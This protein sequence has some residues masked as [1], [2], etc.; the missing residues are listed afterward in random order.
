MAVQTVLWISIIASALACPLVLLAHLRLR[1]RHAELTRR[2][3]AT[4]GE[5][6][7]RLYAEDSLV[8]AYRK[9]VDALKA[10]I[11]QGLI[12]TEY[13]PIADLSSGEVRGVEALTRFADGRSPDVWFQEAAELGIGPQL[14]IAAMNKAL[15]NLS[16]LPSGFVSLNASPATLW[17]NGFREL[18]ERREVPA[19]RI[20]VE[21]TEHE[22]VDNY[23]RIRTTLERLRRLGVRL[24]VD[25]VGAGFATLKHVLQLRPEIVKID[26]SL[27]SGIH[28]D[29][30]RLSLVS[31]LVDVAERM[32]A[33]IVAEGV[34]S[35][36][37]ANALWS[38]GIE[39]GQ[40]FFMCR[41]T[42]PPIRSIRTRFP[43]RRAID[44]TAAAGS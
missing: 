34:E 28:T 6:T 7:A 19:D 16:E 21:L 12:R 37:E 23:D 14:E 41:P 30:V 33:R 35:I 20:V 2:A 9:K 26:R 43:E 11:E 42:L 15:T 29:D 44:L 31:A 1:S 4:S 32:D 17:S 10:A 5:L 18:L 25:D 3:E 38:I 22:F 40:G 8:Q 24:A 39:M 27:I 13:Q 36:E